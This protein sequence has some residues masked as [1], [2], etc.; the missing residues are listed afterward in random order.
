MKKKSILV[1]LF[2]SIIT[3]VNGASI[4][5]LKTKPDTL[6][7]VSE[8]FAFGDFTWLNG[9]DRRH[10]DIL[11]SKYFTPRIYLD[12][13]L[14]ESNRHPIDNTVVGSTV[15]ARNNEFEISDAAFGGDFH[16]GNVRASIVTQLGTRVS[17][18]ARTDLSV[19]H[20]QYDLANAYKYF[21]EANA[22]YHFNIWHGINVDA[23]IFLSYIG[24]FSFYNAENWSYQPSFTSDNTPW[25]FNGIRVQLFPTNKL[26]I[27][28][29]I[30]NGWQSYGKYNQGFGFGGSIM[31]RPK[32]FLDFVTNGYLGHDTQ[33][34]VNRTRYHSD[35]TVQIRF[36]KSPVTFISMEAISLTGD[37]GWEIGDGVNGFNSS[38]SFGPAQYF[39]SGMF[40]NRMQFVNNTFGWTFG[41]GFINN[42][43]RYLV[44]P[45]PGAASAVPAIN[46][47]ITGTTGVGL[48]PF[49]LNA[50]DQFKG[51]DFSTTLDWM[52]SEY[53]TFRIELV[54]RSANVP[55][56]N[57]PGGVTSP[58]GYTNTPYG[59]G[60]ANPNWRPDLVK[61]ETRLLGALLVRF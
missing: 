9:N 51:L 57:G 47:V 14:T 7:E 1:L 15:M 30:T 20:G 43:G 56:F 29:W 4:D 59:P 39:L 61:S 41:G 17:E 21:S 33:D 58:D 37:V 44:L 40:Y 25:F 42:P 3:S 2:L 31:Y 36:Y 5:T 6:K 35:N 16:F 19:L 49:T 46:N 11:D 48:Y 23:G 55:Y 54:H 22:G 60:T 34:A 8:P 38:P 45:P 18:V 28:T 26:K 12:V 50:G 53:I 52:P 32:E 27:E 24:L 10:T 13:N